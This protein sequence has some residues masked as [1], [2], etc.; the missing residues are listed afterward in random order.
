MGMER[1][2]GLAELRLELSKL[3]IGCTVYSHEMILT[4]HN[5]RNG[6]CVLCFILKESSNTHTTHHK[7]PGI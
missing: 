4:N 6:E 1:D 2:G 5:Y 7:H 3:Y